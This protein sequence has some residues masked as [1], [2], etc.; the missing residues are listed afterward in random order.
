MVS[1][2]TM[3]AKQREEAEVVVKEYEKECTKLITVS[4]GRHGDTTLLVWVH[5]GPGLNRREAE[6]SSGGT[7][8]AA[9]AG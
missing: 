9:A 5:A 4:S 1:K 7:G 6:E 2:L 8:E 3:A